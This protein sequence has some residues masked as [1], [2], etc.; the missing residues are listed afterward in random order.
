MGTLPPAEVAEGLGLPLATADRG[1]GN[2]QPHGNSATSGG[3]VLSFTAAGNGPSS[4]QADESLP[5]LLGE[6]L[7]PVPARLVAM[8][9]KGDY[10]DMAKLLRDNLE[11]HRRGWLQDSS[12]A[13]S[14]PTPKRQCREI[15]DLLSWVQCFGSYMGVVNSRYPEKIKQLLAYQTLI[16]R[17]ARRCGGQWLACLR[18]YVPPT[19]GW[20]SIRRLV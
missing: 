1:E 11:A 14:C 2:V 17:E 15:P 3:N 7:A 8:I 6:G 9:L 18:L 12:V 5:F 4:S 16:V 13:D 10:V 20:Q 19:S